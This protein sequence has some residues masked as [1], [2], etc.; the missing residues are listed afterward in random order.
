M[1]FKSLVGGFVRH[2]ITVG[3][4]WLAAEGYTNANDNQMLIGAGM[5]IFGIL[6]SFYEK[7]RRT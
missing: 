2:A 4:G 6:W 7:A 5:V 1:M 3:A